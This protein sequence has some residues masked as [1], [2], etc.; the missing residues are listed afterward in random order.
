MD[1]TNDIK[2]SENNKT[3]IYDNKIDNAKK[4]LNT[5]IDKVPDKKEKIILKNLVFGGGGV[6]GLAYIGLLKIL[7]QHN[8]IKNL[9]VIIGS[10]AGSLMA[11]AI[12]LGYK[13]QEMIDYLMPFKLN[14]FINIT[15][16]SILEFTKDYGLD[17]GDKL[18]SFIKGAISYKGFSENITLK[19]LYDIT[20]KHLIVTASCIVNQQCFYL[21]YKTFPDMPLWLACRASC[22]L[23]ILFK[24]VKYENYL[25]IDGSIMDNTPLYKFKTEMENSVA[26]KFS[27]NKDLNNFVGYIRTIAHCF[28]N[29]D[30]NLEFDKNIVYIDSTNVE[31]VQMV[32]LPLLND[33]M[34]NCIKATTEKFI[35]LN[36]I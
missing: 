35:E 12:C 6:K 32:D 15:A 5:S 10:S 16:K 4:K 11:L 14:R 9:K 26:F 29:Y 7:Y 18:E 28:K 17:K 34:N 33:M 27:C 19:Q 36:F 3:N 31:T 20:K 23:P 13:C 25:F 2:I 1:N 21:D 30:P 8:L 22:G 24:P